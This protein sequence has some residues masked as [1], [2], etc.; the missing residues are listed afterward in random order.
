M[1]VRFVGGEEERATMTASGRPGLRETPSAL[2]SAE[3]AFGSHRRTRRNK[4]QAARRGFRFGAHP[5][6]E[7]AAAAPPSPARHSGPGAT[8]AAA[9]GRTGWRRSVAGGAKRYWREDAVA[10]RHYFSPQ[11]GAADHP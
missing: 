9:P 3:E 10:K 8:W 5:D 7:S 2:V 11:A 1:K 4:R 6:F